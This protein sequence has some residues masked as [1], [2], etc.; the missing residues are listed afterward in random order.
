MV[1]EELKL[2]RK[3]WRKARRANIV[4]V[5]KYRE[6]R[7]EYHSKN[8]ERH[9]LAMKKYQDFGKRNLMMKARRQRPD[10]KFKKN[11]RVLSKLRSD[12]IYHLN[13][14]LSCSIF[15]SI[16]DNKQGRRW[17]D[18]TVYTVEQLKEH[19]EAKFQPGMSWENY[20]KWHIDH[21]IP[22][23]WWEYEKPE[24][25]EFKQCWSLANL[26]PLWKI[27]NIKKGN[28]YADLVR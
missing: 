22:K 13:R 10:W 20:G 3:E 26:Q 19:L 12:L 25:R 17:E 9:K 16:R 27:D 6:R 11:K 4:Y 23:S 5:E 2:K 24:D 18:L 21:V 28:G 14:R 7:R 1:A 15:Q 8:K